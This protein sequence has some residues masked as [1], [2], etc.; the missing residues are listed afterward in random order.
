MSLC[1]PLP[2]M[3]LFMVGSPSLGECSEAAD[4]GG[5][6]ADDK[7]LAVLSKA[8]SVCWPFLRSYHFSIPSK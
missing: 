5:V 8:S 6:G 7:D 4:S 3:F 2:H 1:S